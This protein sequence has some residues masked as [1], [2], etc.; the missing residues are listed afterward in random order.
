MLKFFLQLQLES[1]TAVHCGI[2]F[3]MIA[4][5]LYCNIKDEVYGIWQKEILFSIIICKF[6][7]LSFEW[8]DCLL[9]W[10]PATWHCINSWTSMKKSMKKTLDEELL[11]GLGLWH[12]LLCDQ[13]FTL[14]FFYVAR[15]RKQPYWV[16]ASAWKTRA[17]VWERSQ[18]KNVLEDLR[19]AK[20]SRHGKYKV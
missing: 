1:S 9:R 17:N 10:N 20:E 15:L 3:N 19:E 13:D 11:K 7:T 2:T 5:L 6:H 14:D 4:V 16:Y 8:E 18:R 12:W